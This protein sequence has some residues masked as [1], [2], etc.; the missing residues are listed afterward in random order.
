[1]NPSFQG[2]G[3]VLGLMFFTEE[4]HLIIAFQQPR[5]SKR[6]LGFFSLN[7]ETWKDRE[8]RYQEVWTLVDPTEAVIIKTFSL[9]VS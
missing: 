3:Y 5:K 2:T 8:F 6:W 7:S 9:R 4:L 1:M